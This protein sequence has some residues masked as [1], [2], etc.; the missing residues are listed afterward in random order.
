MSD[1]K[2]AIPVEREPEELGGEFG[3]Y[4]D[5]YFCATPTPFWNIEKN[6][7]VCEKCAKVYIIQDIKE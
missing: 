5:C 2:D 6:T 4:E 7:P 1:N 3:C